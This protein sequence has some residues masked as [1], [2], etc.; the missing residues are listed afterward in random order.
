MPYVTE[1]LT[2]QIEETDPQDGDMLY[3][4]K[5]AVSATR[6]RRITLSTL[7]EFFGASESY[8]L[9]DGGGPSSTYSNSVDGG[10]PGSW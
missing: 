1:K 5:G 10:G 4:V 9:I 6:R 7:K 2:K 8:D 3:L